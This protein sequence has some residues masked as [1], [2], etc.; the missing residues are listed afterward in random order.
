MRAWDIVWFLKNY[1]RGHP[2]RNPI[3]HVAVNLGRDLL[4]RNDQ[5][6]RETDRHGS[7][8]IVRDQGTALI[9]DCS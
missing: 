9:V 2:C 8:D 6:S 7:F 3:S 4:S 1:A 5:E